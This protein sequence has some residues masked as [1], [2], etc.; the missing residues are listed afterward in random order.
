MPGKATA[1]A[2]RSSAGV[3]PWGLKGIPIDFVADAV[4]ASFP[5]LPLSDLAGAF[6]AIGIVY[7]DAVPPDTLSV[8]VNDT[9]GIAL[10]A[11]SGAIISGTRRISISPPAPFTPGISLVLGANTTVS[12]AVRII[13]YIV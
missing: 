11:G 2:V 12:A 13:L 4:D 9:D 1:G 3:G 5:S 7:D 10:L 6:V 8:V